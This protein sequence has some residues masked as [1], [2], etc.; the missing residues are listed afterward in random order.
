MQR[1]F[2]K[3]I[4][5]LM[6]EGKT[7]ITLFDIVTFQQN[8]RNNTKNAELNSLDK[9]RKY[10]QQYVLDRA[11]LTVCT[12]ESLTPGRPPRLT[13]N[14][15]GKFLQPLTRELVEVPPRPTISEL[16]DAV[17]DRM[18]QKDKAFWVDKPGLN[19]YTLHDAHYNCGMTSE[20][21]QP[22]H[23]D[24]FPRSYQYDLEC[25]RFRRLHAC[26]GLKAAAKGPQK[27]VSPHCRDCSKW[28]QPGLTP[29]QL[30][31]AQDAV[32]KRWR[33]YPD[34]TADLSAEQIR[35]SMDDVGRPFQNE[36]CNWYYKN[37]PTV[38]YN[39]IIRKFSQ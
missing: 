12:D 14:T 26:D 2:K 23:Q 30:A 8:D 3:N 21:V 6:Q 39:C 32:Q 25:V 35:A 18:V 10:S 1:Y 34:L 27:A 33:Y 37:Y 22:P 15:I 38:K 17:I 11:P 24:V 9:S 7:T 28:F 20:K 31:W 4:N 36:A 5:V 19:A 29:F 13:Q 16:P